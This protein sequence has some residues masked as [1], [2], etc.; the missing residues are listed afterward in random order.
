MLYVF[1]SAKNLNDVDLFYVYLSQRRIGFITS[2]ATTRPHVY[3]E[4]RAKKTR[5]NAD[6]YRFAVNNSTNIYLKPFNYKEFHIVHLKMCLL[7]FGSYQNV[8]YYM[9]I[10]LVIIHIFEKK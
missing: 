9:Y 2:L 4:P 7:Q 3:R 5:V 10:T 6:F 8:L 1:V